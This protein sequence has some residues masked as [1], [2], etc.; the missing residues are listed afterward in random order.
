MVSYVYG[1]IFDSGCPVLVNTVN[2]VGVMGRGLALGFKQEFP[3][4]FEEY[5]ELCCL[6]KI[7]PGKLWVWRSGLVTVV[8][9]PT[10]DHWR[11]PSKMEWIDV[12][13]QLLAKCP[14]GPVAMPYPGCGFGGLRR[15]DVR[16]LIDQYL[17]GHPVE[18]RVFQHWDDN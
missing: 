4:M 3:E 15:E 16:P 14:E 2:C 7:Q 10:K 18:F 5:R 1:S 11:H 17:G 13:L 12:G 9:F 6:K 8:N